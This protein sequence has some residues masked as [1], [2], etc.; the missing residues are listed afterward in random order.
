MGSCV[1]TTIITKLEQQP[2]RQKHV[3]VRHVYQYFTWLGGCFNKLFV[4]RQRIMINNVCISVIRALS[5]WYWR[6][7]VGR[8]CIDV[9][10]LYLRVSSFHRPDS[11]SP[12]VIPVPGAALWKS[13]P[14]SPTWMTVREWELC[15]GCSISVCGGWDSAT[16][17][18]GTE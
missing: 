16:C 18:L 14:E 6:H 17:C 13:P 7:L 9:I 12:P 8:L 15:L 2:P 11:D 1:I 4:A 10:S 3:H 5:D